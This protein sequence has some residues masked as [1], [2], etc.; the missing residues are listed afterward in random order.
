MSN[1][2]KITQ[3][4]KNLENLVQKII[5]LGEAF[6][7]EEP[8][9]EQTKLSESTLL[10]DVKQSIYDY[11]MSES[12]IN[13]EES[14]LEKSPSISMILEDIDKIVENLSNY[15]QQSVKSF[16]DIRILVDRA[17]R[18]IKKDL[19]QDLGK[20]MEM[21]LL[22]DEEG[23]ELPTISPLEIADPIR[24]TRSFVEDALNELDKSLAGILYKINDTY[25]EETSQIMSETQ[26]KSQNQSLSFDKTIDKLRNSQKKL[27]DSWK[28]K[29][30]TNLDIMNL[31]IKRIGLGVPEEIKEESDELVKILDRVEEIFDETVDNLFL[32]YRRFM[33]HTNN[34]IS[35]QISQEDLSL[36][37]IYKQ[38][39]ERFWTEPLERV[40]FIETAYEELNSGYVSFID[41]LLKELENNSL[42]ELEKNQLTTILEEHQSIT[43]KNKFS[44]ETREEMLKE[45]SSIKQK[46]SLIFEEKKQHII[47]KITNECLTKFQ[48]ERERENSKNIIVVEKLA[49][50]QEK[51]ELLI[52]KAEQGNEGLNSIKK[53][54]EN[55]KQEILETS[56]NKAENAIFFGKIVDEEITSMIIQYS[57]N[58]SEYF[59]GV[60]NTNIQLITDKLTLFS[61]EW[62]KKDKRELEKKQMFLEA[63]KK[64]LE[65]LKDSMEEIGFNKLLNETKEEF[66]RNKEELLQNSMSKWTELS[67]LISNKYLASLQEGKRLLLSTS[68]KN[69]KDGIED[70]KKIEISKKLDKDHD[71]DALL[72]LKDDL[73]EEINKL[74]QLTNDT[75]DQILVP[76]DGKVVEMKNQIR[77]NQILATS[78]SKSASEK[79]QTNTGEILNEGV[80]SMHVF[81]EEF[82][83]K[84]IA[85]LNALEK[86][87]GGTFTSVFEALDR[88]NKNQPN[89][90]H[91]TAAVIREN[92]V[93]KMDKLYAIIQRH[94]NELQDDINFLYAKNRVD[95]SLNRINTKINKIM[96]EEENLHSRI[97]KLRANDDR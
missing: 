50:V 94:I 57:K 4:E 20:T 70:I 36:R 26:I 12:L 22:T 93:I 47:E 67:S 63:K 17:L 79:L 62:F 55:L 60:L 83:N 72:R 71:G 77:E 68:K 91:T 61:N 44:D 78:I 96:E 92:I 82:I 56:S 97:N 66:T 65:E 39:Y 59:L 64:E 38:E 16:G 5:E 14:D 32:T 52:N 19:Y 95:S 76:I 29:V 9:Q 2:E 28:I 51:V 54:I 33:D 58:L 25:L 18:D 11:L 73:L 3:E 34:S 45:I 24:R 87:L 35:N 75:N 85:Q 37:E 46:I 8:S 48:E 53:D 84:L 21:I 49:N 15:E 23:N 31:K 42:E 43:F 1:S 90:L 88:F 27:L 13:R 6:D 89:Q 10:I 41:L 74:K 81:V 40:N 80:G 7:K 69:K 30:I 86:N